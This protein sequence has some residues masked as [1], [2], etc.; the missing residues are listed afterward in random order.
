MFNF[1]VFTG[2]MFHRKPNIHIRLAKNSDVF[3]LLNLI[4]DCRTEF[5]RPID[6]KK[7]DQDLLNIQHY[8]KNGLFLVAE[9]EGKI[10]AC[11]SMF[12]DENSNGHLSKLLVNKK[13]RKLGIGSEILEML[14]QHAKIKGS[15]QVM[16]SFS[17]DMKPAFKFL[18]GFNFQEVST[19]MPE[20]KNRIRKLVLD[21]RN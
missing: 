21:F 6:L 13:Y 1:D 16:A 2:K 4:K 12:L 7:K 15:G 11:G 14:I 5:G 17:N 19:A 8:Y 10:V 9:E 3:E 18:E 20:T